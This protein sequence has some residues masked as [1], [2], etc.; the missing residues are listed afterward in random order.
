VAQGTNDLC[1]KSAE[2]RAAAYNPRRTILVESRKGRL[3]VN[4]DRKIGTLN[5]IVHVRY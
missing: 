1:K 5:Y 4:L 3:E 2:M